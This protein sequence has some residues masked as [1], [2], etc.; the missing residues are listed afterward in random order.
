MIDNTSWCTILSSVLIPRLSILQQHMVPP[1]F[2]N[3]LLWVPGELESSRTYLH[4]SDLKSS[5]EALAK[6]RRK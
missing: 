6:I 5:D 1:T 3:N 2:V 4:L